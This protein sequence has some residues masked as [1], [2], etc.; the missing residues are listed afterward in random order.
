MDVQFGDILWESLP[1]KVLVHLHGDIL[2]VPLNR[3]L[4]PVE[5]VQRLYAHG[6]A[7]FDIVVIYLEQE[8]D[9]SLLQ[10][11]QRVVRAASGQED[12]TVL[13]GRSES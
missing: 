12:Q 6:G 5:I 2:V 7:H 13:L 10:V 8:L 9:S 3:D 4:M 11:Y 1:D